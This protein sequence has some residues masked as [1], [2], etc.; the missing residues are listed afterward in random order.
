MEPLSWTE[1]FRA[2]HTLAG[3]TR[4]SWPQP[5]SGGFNC[6]PD[7]TISDVY[8]GAAWILTAPGDWILGIPAVAR[9]FELETPV[10]GHLFSYWLGAM[11]AM[12]IVLIILAPFVYAHEDRQRRRRR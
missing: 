12:P 4:F 6:H 11:I 7:F 10:A 9:F 5:D 8:G 3:R 1:C 2:M